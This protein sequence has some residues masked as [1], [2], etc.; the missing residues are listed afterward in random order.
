MVDKCLTIA[1]TPKELIEEQDIDA[2]LKYSQKA[3]KLLEGIQKRYGIPFEYM[4]FNN[5]QVGVIEEDIKP[6]K[7][8]TQFSGEM[9]GVR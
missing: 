9:Y 4:F 8:F 7:S 1:N 5:L 3:I 2:Y 6:K